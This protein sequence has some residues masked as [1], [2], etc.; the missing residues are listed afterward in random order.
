MAAIA[1]YLAND[2]VLYAEPDYVVNVDTTTPTDPLWAQ[3]WDM[4]K[5]SA[6]QAWDIQSNAADVMVAI[7][8]TGID[9]THPDLQ[10]NLWVNYADRSHGFTCINGTC[11]AGGQD[12][13]GHGTHVAGTIGAMADNGQGM[14][15]INWR[16]QLLSCKF[17]DANGSGNVSD[18]VLCLDKILT[19]KEQG[20]NIRL[21][22]NSWA[23]ARTAKR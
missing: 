7:L 1:R 21:T 5:I 14:A 19:L 10:S 11:V 6:P 15:G 16:T 9:Y 13:Y 17:L 18:A 20:F 3:Q 2:S 22:S 12:D 8:D 23:G 4:A